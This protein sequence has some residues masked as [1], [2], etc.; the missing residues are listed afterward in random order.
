MFEPAPGLAALDHILTHIKIAAE[1]D[2]FDVDKETITVYINSAEGGELHP[3]STPVPGG[4]SAG[5]GGS[6]AANAASAVREAIAA[7]QGRSHAPLTPAPGLAALD[8][9]LTHIKIAAENDGFE[10]KDCHPHSFP[11]PWRRKVIT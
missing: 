11:S 10:P 9:I 3:M 8:H 5:A 4:S 7:S 6:A 1:D 2:G